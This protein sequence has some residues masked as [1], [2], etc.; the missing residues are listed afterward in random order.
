MANYVNIT[1][2][3][4]G[5]QTPTMVIS[6]GATTSATQ[7]VTLTI[8]TADG[9]TTGYQMRIWGDVDNAY[10][11]AVQS[12]QGA[13]QLVAY[14]T[15][16]QIKLSALDGAKTINIILYDDVLNPSST[17]TQNITLNTSVPTVT[18]SAQSVTKVSKV[19]TKDTMTFNFTSDQNYTDY[20]VKVVSSTGALDTQ[21]T[22]IPTT[23]GSSNVSGT[24]SFT[25]ATPI[26]VTVKGT[27]LETA[28]AGDGSKIV[29]VFVRNAAGTWSV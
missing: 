7:L 25:G 1:L 13:S 9:T 24:G 21:G 2:D 19:A 3:T 12:T 15:S 22:Q 28:S 26:T 20:K 11:A 10:D 16:K 8:G 18:V 5:P 27:D 14:A 6:G 29:K 17:V 4:Q 23:D